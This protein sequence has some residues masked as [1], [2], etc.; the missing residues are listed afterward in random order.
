MN[1]SL[2]ELSCAKHI[3]PFS[4]SF[5]NVLNFVQVYERCTVSE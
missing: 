3:V 1:L 2:F 4:F 5:A